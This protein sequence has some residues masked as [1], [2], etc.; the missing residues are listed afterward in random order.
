MKTLK[1]ILNQLQDLYH[2]QSEPDRYFK[3]KCPLNTFLWFSYR[4]NIK[5]LIESLT[6]KINQVASKNYL[7]RVKSGEAV[8]AKLKRLL[9]RKQASDKEISKYWVNFIQRKSDEIKLLSSKY[10]SNQK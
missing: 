3:I 6:P 7:N 5:P 4:V 10:Q 2:G 1:L 8:N 9:S